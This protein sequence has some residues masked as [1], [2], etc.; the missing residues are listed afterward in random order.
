M[1][2]R[3]PETG[4]FVSTDDEVS[5]SRLEGELTFEQLNQYTEGI[6]E[7]TMQGAARAR[8]TEWGPNE[9]NDLVMAQTGSIKMSDAAGIERNQVGEIVAIE[10]TVFRATQE[11][12][13]NSGT[14]PG[15]ARIDMQWIGGTPDADFPDRTNEGLPAGHEAL[16]EDDDGFA[17]WANVFATYNSG[18]AFENDGNLLWKDEGV[19][20]QGFNDTVNGT[21]GGGFADISA[22][23][24]LRDYAGTFGRGPLVY[25]ET[26]I[27]P[28]C[29]IALQNWE[30]EDIRIFQVIKLY[31]DVYET[32]ADEY[33]D[34]QF[35]TAGTVR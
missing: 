4:K 22:G 5:P 3:D 19:I 28:V 24:Q 1:A 13:G 16:D 27:V 20:G 32:A 30:N 2:Q 33:E 6:T 11:A 26:E 23:H 7:V 8:L 12:R 29:S 9:A 17:E 14:T 35:T 21:G 15:I 34:V 10:R 31:I 25:P 18:N